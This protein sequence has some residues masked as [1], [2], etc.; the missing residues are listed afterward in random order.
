MVQTPSQY[1]SPSDIYTV[2]N[3]ICQANLVPIKNDVSREPLPKNY[4]RTVFETHRKAAQEEHT[5]KPIM[6]DVVSFGRWKKVTL[7][8][9]W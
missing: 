4:A 5:M 6:K 3:S 8:E 9:D 1:P 7:F 2:H